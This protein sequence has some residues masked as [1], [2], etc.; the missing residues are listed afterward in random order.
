MIIHPLW[1]IQIDETENWVLQILFPAGGFHHL[2][3]NRLPLVSAMKVLKASKKKSSRKDRD[4]DNNH[5]KKNGK[6]GQKG[7][8]SKGL[9]GKDKKQ[10]RN[11]VA[12][13]TS[14]IKQW[15]LLKTL[16]LVLGARTIVEVASSKIQ[17][18]ERLDAP[19]GGK[20]VRPP[21]HGFACWMPYV[22][23]S[24]SYALCTCPCFC[25]AVLYCIVLRVVF[26]IY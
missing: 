15:M 9:G 24:I 20:N 23:S 19:L 10:F 22:D 11:L 1:L 17:Y 21:I 13:L 18:S 6:K 3:S 14:A 4:K 12:G 26:F 2:N 25:C 16:I 5:N 7:S 8:S